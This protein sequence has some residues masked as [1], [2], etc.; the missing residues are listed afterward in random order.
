[1]IVTIYRD[2][3]SHDSTIAEVTIIAI[4]ATASCYIVLN[5]SYNCVT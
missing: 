3:K 5:H 1:M 4:T 2:T